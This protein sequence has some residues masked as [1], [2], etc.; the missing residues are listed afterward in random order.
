[1][2]RLLRRQ[3][4]LFLIV[5]GGLGNQLFQLAAARSISELAG[6]ELWLDLSSYESA[7]QQVLSRKFEAM[8]FVGSDVKI[9]RIP[10]IPYSVVGQKLFS[11]IRLLGDVAPSIAVRLGLLSSTR[12]DFSNL[13]SHALSGARHLDSYFVGIGDNPIYNR[14]VS[15]IICKLRHSGR[16]KAS[17]SRIA[18]HLR[19]GDYLAINERLVPDRIRLENAVSYFVNKGFNQFTIYSDDVELAH[20]KLSEA[21]PGVD[22]QV[23]DPNLSPVETLKHMSS[24]SGIICSSSTFSWWAAKAISSG[25]GRVLFPDPGKESVPNL[26]LDSEW[27]LY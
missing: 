8:P 2:A 16:P 14:E 22:L 6:K 13:S 10:P 20:T 1:M 21:A 9:K 7:S 27:N 25:G 12:H 19:L 15:E 17:Q 11:G 24:H 4:K 23:A 18:I 3:P 26:L 5:R